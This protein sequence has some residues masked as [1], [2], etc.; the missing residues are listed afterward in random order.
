[1]GVEEL[2]DDDAFDPKKLFDEKQYST[3]IINREGFDKKQNSIADLLEAL[4]DD[5]NTRQENESLFAKLKE[6]NAQQML[7]DAVEAAENTADK[8]K[9][10]AACWESCL[11]FTP[12]FPFFVKLVCHPDFGVALEALSVVE[13]CEGQIDELILA[14]ALLTV[15]SLPEKPHE[16]V[17]DLVAN[18]KQRI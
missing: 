1:M 2:L 10:L 5:R 3:L 15:Q 18:I 12:H 14:D 9:L 17:D 4:L 7:V 11:D 6:L 16:L 8:I 13:S